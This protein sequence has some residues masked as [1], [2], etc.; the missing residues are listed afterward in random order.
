MKRLV[1]LIASLL[2]MAN[3]HAANR[4]IDIIPKPAS[5]KV[6][7]GSFVVS[8]DTPIVV[9]SDD[10]AAAAGIFAEEMQSDFGKSLEITKADRRKS[11]RLALSASLKDE[12][13]SL[14]ID[15]SG[16]AISGGSPKAVFYGLQSL[17]QLAI[18]GQHT[19][20]GIKLPA[21]SIN[22]APFFGYRGAMLDVCRHIFSVADIKKYI[23]ILALHKINR[24]HWHLTDD[25]GWRIE[26]KRYPEL[27]RIGAMRKETVVGRYR[28]TAE[29]DGKPY[30]GIFSQDEVR[31]IV[32]YAADRYIEIIPEIEM[33]GHGV[34]ALSTYPWLGCSGGPYEVRTTW[35]VSE[36]VFCA[37]KES[38][39]EFLENVLAEVI[40]LFPSEYIHIG[41][42]ECP[43]KAWKACELCQKRIADEGL[44][45]EAELQSYFMERIERWLNAHGRRIIGWDEILQGGITKSATIMSWRGTKGGIAAAKLGN[46]V[47]MAPNSHCYIDYYQ[48]SDPTA[49]GEP[50][51]N[52]HNP[53]TVAT[54]YSLD[55]YAGL[56]AEE[57]QY[58]MGVQVN[59]WTEY[60]SDFD[61]VQHMLLPRLAALAEVGWS[62][63]R[64]DYD[65]FKARLGALRKVYDRN[66]YKYAPY[67]FKG[68]E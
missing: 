42:D 11:I 65:D 25:Q 40:E 51:A 10:L 26:I 48:T 17:K 16:I 63:D 45:D 62:Y 66:G 38:T 33:P 19:G 54:L 29:Y 68:I 64:K 49:N 32:K 59:L 14:N 43:K 46:K 56:N 23:D 44:K 6:G 3:A 30:G 5:V 37:G 36:E 47:I 13:Y 22:D 35:G 15:K 60:I 27:S 57:Q 67:F 58:I 53:V 55:P 39:F 7:A 18:A 24:F 52:G 1:F 20:K 4:S 41:G 34:A 8:A 50:L 21:V 2:V 28:H 9:E 12:E 61:H 31:E